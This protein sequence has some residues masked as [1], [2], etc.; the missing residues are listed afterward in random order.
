MP[1]AYFPAVGR[2][3]D[4]RRGRIQGG[5]SVCCGLCATQPFGARR[6]QGTANG[7]SLAP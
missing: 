7:E 5:R 4:R 3:P 2:E 1:V 6:T